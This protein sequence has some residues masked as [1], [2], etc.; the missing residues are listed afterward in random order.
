MSKLTEKQAF[1][2]INNKLPAK[3]N[4]SRTATP[5]NAKTAKTTKQSKDESID[6]SEI[7]KSIKEVNDTLKELKSIYLSEIA[8]R[9]DSTPDPVSL[10]RIR[11]VSSI[12]N[13]FSLV[14]VSILGVCLL[15]TFFPQ[16]LPFIIHKSEEVWTQLIKYWKE[17]NISYALIRDTSVNFRDTSL[18]FKDTGLK[19][20]NTSLS[21]GS[22]I[23]TQL[24]KDIRQLLKET[25]PEYETYT[26]KIP[27]DNQLHTPIDITDLAKTLNEIHTTLNE[28]K[29]LYAAER[30]KKDEDLEAGTSSSTAE[31]LD[32]L[33]YAIYEKVDQIIDRLIQQRKKE[34][35]SNR[36]IVF[37]ELERAKFINTGIA[38]VIIIG[39]SFAIW[40]MV[41]IMIW[42]Q[43]SIQDLS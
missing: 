28:F 7:V 33:D 15:I 11:F 13:Y 31:R 4:V 1:Q 21:H 10:E 32:D 14:V 17:S 9:N 16:L 23:V 12:A 29:S 42:Y 40:A 37:T 25:I 26:E 30:A 3:A 19:F 22:K 2:I 36:R 39:V 24:D 41:S 27:N 38:I 5:P 18:K 35:K 6:V 43:R 34:L 20:I 8:K